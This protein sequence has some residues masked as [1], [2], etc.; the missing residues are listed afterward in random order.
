M[1]CNAAPAVWVKLTESISTTQ[2]VN[3]GPQV[4]HTGLHEHNTYKDFSDLIFQFKNL[5]FNRVVF[6][7]TKI[8]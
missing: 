5:F 6:Q 1:Y 2:E 7:L 8:I 4:Q 3:L